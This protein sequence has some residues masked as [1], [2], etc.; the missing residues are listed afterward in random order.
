MELVESVDAAAADETRDRT[1][2][3]IKIVTEYFKKHPVK[4]GS[5]P[6]KKTAKKAAPKKAA[7]KASAK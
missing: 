3:L 6:A 1:N 4:N 7:K 5:T 2:M